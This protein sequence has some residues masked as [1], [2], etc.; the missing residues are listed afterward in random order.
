MLHHMWS[1]VLI[2]QLRP[3][4]SFP[5][6]RRLPENVPPPCL[7][8]WVTAGRRLLNKQRHMSVSPRRRRDVDTCAHIPSPH[9]QPRH[10]AKLHTLDLSAELWAAGGKK[11]ASPTFARVHVKFRTVAATVG[12]V[13]VLPG[14]QLPL[15]D[16][17]LVF[18]DSVYL[19][20]GE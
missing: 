16:Y 19:L 7:R 8:C 15:H 1:V 18:L 14:G 6:Q 2:L 12:S 5:A 4:P 13:V 17:I 10:K 11:T 9:I 20:Y 3:L